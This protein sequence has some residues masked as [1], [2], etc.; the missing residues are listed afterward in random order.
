MTL[1]VSLSLRTGIGIAFVYALLTMSSRP[2]AAQDAP[3]PLSGVSATSSGTGRPIA[4]HLTRFALKITPPV[5]EAPLLSMIPS[6]LHVGTA[7]TG[8]GVVTYSLVQGPDG[9]KIDASTG[10]LTWTPPLMME[11]QQASIEVSATDGAL[12]AGVTFTVQV[13]A[14]RSLTTSVSDTAVT[15]TQVGSLKDLRFT[16]PSTVPAGVT[17]TTVDSPDA[18]PVP[19]NIGR[20]SDFFR[21]SPVQVPGD[22]ITVTMPTTGLPAG[23]SPEAVRLYVWA[24]AREALVD[25]TGGSDREWAS[26]SY[27]LKVLLPGAATVLVDRV[28][29]LSFVGYD[30]G[31]AEVIAHAAD[32]SSLQPRVARSRALNAPVVCVPQPQEGGYSAVDTQICTLTGTDLNPSPIVV[33]VRGFRTNAWGYPRPAIEDLLGWLALANAR[34]SAMGMSSDPRIDVIVEDFPRGSRCY[35]MAGCTFSDTGEFFDVLHLARQDATFRADMEVVAAHEY[36]HH[37]QSRTMKKDSINLT[38]FVEHKETNWIVEGTATWFED[39]VFDDIN[40]YRMVFT[41]PLRPILEDGLGSKYSS[42]YDYFAFWKMISSHCPGFSIADVIND[43]SDRTAPSLTGVADF[44]ALHESPQ[45]TCL[46]DQRFGDSNKYLAA[47]LTYYTWATTKLQAISMLDDGE[48]LSFSFAPPTHP[49]WRPDTCTS[50]PDCSVGYGDIVAPP[51]SAVPFLIDQA[52][53]LDGKLVYVQVSPRPS[54]N[55]LWVMASDYHVASL[56]MHGGQENPIHDTITYFYPSNAQAPSTEIAVV[57]PDTVSGAH[58]SIRAAKILPRITVASA[59]CTA[60]PRLSQDPNHCAS[61]TILVKGSVTGVP[62]ASLFYPGAGPTLTYRD[63]FYSGW[64]CPLSSYCESRPGDADTQP[65]GLEVETAPGPCP[66]TYS[67]KLYLYTHEID[68][69]SA[70]ETLNIVCTPPTQ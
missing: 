59:A 1:P 70:T 23:V 32:S 18:P 54:D 46:Y 9:M 63:Y 56:H 28:G 40:S 22:H 12:N 8:S 29:G 25:E 50:S 47:A 37:A 16:F 42:G 66:Y 17:V 67:R 41:L 35:G 58:F 34:F 13:A 3:D 69:A 30:V 24:R 7:Y 52:N 14:T 65:W 21:V 4:R 68:E 38:P 49:P 36:F 55:G 43:V 20:I 10:V 31:A 5:L 61:Y 44:K 48:K 26:S 19:N 51:A 53:N 15:V 62:G 64:S 45:W 33:T 60:G 39:E 57:N 11:G 6:A 2:I 27:G